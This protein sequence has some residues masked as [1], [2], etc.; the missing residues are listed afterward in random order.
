MALDGARLFHVNVNCS[1]LERSRRFYV[2]GL[3]LAAGAHTTT[4]HTQA[5]DAFGLDKARWDA[6]ILLGPQGFDG[7]AIDLLEWLE[8]RPTGAAPRALNERGFQRAGIRVPDLDAAIASLTQAGGAVWSRPVEHA[9]GE[10]TIRI[11]MAND[12]DGVAIELVEGGGP[13]LSFVAV[14]CADLAASVQWYATLGFTEV[15]RFASERAD[16]AHLRIDGPVAMVEV[17][18]S[19]PGS[20]DEL[21]I[22][23]GFDQPP[24]R[25][26]SHRPANALGLWRAAFL[27]PDL[28]GAY[29]RLRDA[30]IA[31]ISP[32]VAMAMGE[33]LPDLRFLCFRG[34]DGEVLELIES[35]Q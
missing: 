34:P 30:G 2:D 12:P 15:A 7:G 17:V 11:V 13:A 29:A 9:A 28:D 24:V 22:L 27:V 14:A 18:L 32:P 16:G 35:P 23:A 21:V 25:D 4:G 8:P 1:D 5:G 33:G 3:G 31:T 6:W 26:A 20:G 19:P 10:R